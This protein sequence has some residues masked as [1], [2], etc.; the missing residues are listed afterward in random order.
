MLKRVWDVRVN[1]VPI[2]IAIGRSLVSGNIFTMLGCVI[3]FPSSLQIIC[4]LAPSS[5]VRAS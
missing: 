5:A 2:R 3:R 1:Y 4:V